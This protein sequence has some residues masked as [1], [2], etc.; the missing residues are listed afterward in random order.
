MH[1]FYGFSIAINNIKMLHRLEK[2]LAFK[3]NDFDPIL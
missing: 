3:K 2:K 1:T